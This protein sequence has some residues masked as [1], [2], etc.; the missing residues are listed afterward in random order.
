[1]PGGYAGKILRVDLTAG[2][3]WDE[4]LP[5]EK[6]MRSY[7]GGTGLGVKYL[8]DEVPPGVGPLEPDNRFI[9]MTGPLTGTAVPGS[10]NSTFVSINAGLGYSLATAHTHGYFGPNLKYA[11]YDGFIVQGAAD[12]PV[13]LLLYDGKVELRDAGNVWGKDTHETE[14]LLKEEVGQREASVAA[15]GPAGEN[16]I[17][18]ACIEN[19][20]HH[21]AAHGGLGAVMGSKKLKAIVAYGRK[22][23]QLANPKELLEAAEKWRAPENVSLMGGGVTA[24]GGMTRCWDLLGKGSILAG[25]NLSSPDWG[26]ELGASFVEECKKFKVVARPCFACPHGCSYKVYVTTGP[27]KGGVFTMG[28]GGENLEASAAMI[29]VTD[30]GSIFWLCEKYDRLGFGTSTIGCAISL[31]FE[32][33]ERGILTKEDTGGLELNWGNAEAASELLDMIVAREGLGKILA[34]GP[35]KAA[36]AIGGDAPKYAVHMKGEGFNLHDWRGR[37]QTFLGQA[38]AGAGPRWEG[39]GMDVFGAEPDIGYHEPPP[40]FTMEG[41]AEAIRMAQIKKLFDDSIGVCWFMCHAIPGIFRLEI[42]ALAAITGWQ[43]ISE[44]ELLTAG[45]RIANMQRVFSIGRGIRLEDDLDIGA[46]MLEP[47]TDGIA[48]GKTIAPYLKDAVLEYYRLMGWEEETGKP[49]P[50]TLTRL[51]LQHLVE[52]IW[53]KD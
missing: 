7:I 49:L 46:R 48:R 24:R 41:A 20:K 6:T 8:L 5:D 18:G 39:K 16:L 36:E 23:F 34:E 43:G 29:G 33:Y 1:M 35:K 51:G 22:S 47:P 27:H 17:G 15:I 32:C 26:K 19:D 13:Y 53:Q 31:A 52:K 28:G 3:T 50:E 14:D 2:K 11:G 9:C 42:E 4:D 37:W 38:V 12:K 30:A 25:K 45:E 21:T 40:P 10:N 44:N